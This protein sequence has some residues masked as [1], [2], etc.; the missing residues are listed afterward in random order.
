[1]DDRLPAPA[2]AT[3]RTHELP[4]PS[5]LES[6]AAR[7]RPQGRPINRGRPGCY[8]FVGSRKPDA[9][10]P[11]AGH[12]A[13]F[14]IDELCLA[15][16][17]AF[18]VRAARAALRSRLPSFRVTSRIDVARRFCDNTRASFIP[19]L[20]GVASAVK[21]GNAVRSPLAASIPDG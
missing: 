18:L 20:E 15:I 16:G 10:P 1:M 9:S 6:I 3:W 5:E 11:P 2:A 17:T 4:Q 19:A 7:N 8:A 13:K 21:D 12:N 14:D